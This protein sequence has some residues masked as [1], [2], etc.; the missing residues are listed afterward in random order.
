[1]SELFNPYIE[2]PV[3]TQF[4]NTLAQSLKSPNLSPLL[5]QVWGVGGVGK[6]TLS[7]RAEAANPQTVAAF[8]EFDRTEG[9]TE[10]IGV[11]RALHQQ[12]QKAFAGQ[13]DPFGKRNAEYFDAIHKLNSESE[14]GKG[15][16]TA[17]QIETVKQGVVWAAKGIGGLTPVG[18]E[19]A[20]TVA[21]AVVESSTLI[22][23][24]ADRLRNLVQR[25]RATKGKRELQELILAPLSRLTD[26]FVESLSHWS[27]QRP[28]L[29]RLDTYEKAPA[30][31]DSWL[32]STLLGNH[33]NLRDLRLRILVTGRHELRNEGWR[34]LKQDRP[35]WIEQW[36]LQRLT[37]EQTQD[38]LQR[39]GF[40]D[41]T[42]IARIAKITKGLPYYLNWI[43]PAAPRPS[44]SWTTGLK[45]CPCSG[46]WCRPRKPTAPKPTPAPRKF[47]LRFSRRDELLTRG[48][49]APLFLWPSKFPA[50]S[51]CKLIAWIG[52]GYCPFEE[53]STESFCR[54]SC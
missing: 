36:S 20:G 42:Q 37:P 35:G 50:A 27:K 1:M 24:E 9:A 34:K 11:M 14:D 26:A 52:S 47:C 46:R 33:A 18:S 3:A 5:L 30:D 29:L 53:D 19:L 54:I 49:A 6:S 41:A 38:Y 10:P 13:P 45:P 31:V 21:G 16:A 8:V 32:W 40:T 25:H 22:A 17:E 51:L 2:R 43:R 48:A 15:A 23:S 12:L 39:I 44:A 7:R 4:L 28:I